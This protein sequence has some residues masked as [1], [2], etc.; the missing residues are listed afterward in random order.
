MLE[1]VRSLSANE[2]TSGLMC[3]EW[4]HIAGKLKAAGILDGMFPAGAKLC[5]RCIR[6]DWYQ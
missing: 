2:A 4:D 5:T 1:Y 6:H 3:P